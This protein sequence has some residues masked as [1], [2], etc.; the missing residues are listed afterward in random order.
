MAPTKDATHQPARGGA[1]AS[2][3][4]TPARSASGTITDVNMVI[5]EPAWVNESPM[6]DARRNAAT[7]VVG[8]NLYA[9]TGFNLAPNYTDANERFDG[10]SWSTRAP[11]PVRH[12]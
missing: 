10:T 5:N 11:I 8:S 1:A 4:S 3:A 9:I 2:L 7:A 12:A 6:A